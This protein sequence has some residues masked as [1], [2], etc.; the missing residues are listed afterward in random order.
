M[1]QSEQTKNSFFVVSIF[2]SYRVIYRVE[3]VTQK[4]FQHF[5]FYDWPWPSLQNLHHAEGGRTRKEE[6]ELDRCIIFTT[7][8]RMLIDFVSIPHFT[9]Q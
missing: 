3:N 6:A 1:M 8:T 7:E 4:H 5:T 9:D 2:F